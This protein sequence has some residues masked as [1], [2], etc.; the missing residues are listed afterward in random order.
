MT[1]SRIHRGGWT[2]VE[3]VV[4]VGLLGALM[5]AAASVHSA[6]GRTNHYHLTTQRCIAAGQGA[7][8]SISATGRAL[9][10]GDVER[11]WPGLKVDVIRVP[12]A[13]DWAG[14]TLVRVTV[15]GR[16]RGRDVAVVQC[17]YVRPAPRAEGRP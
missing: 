3:A 15:R 1:A 14:L 10:D 6:V 17:R 13:G 11:L 16:S 12:G 2:L 4:S 9:P 7:L 5:A 8:D